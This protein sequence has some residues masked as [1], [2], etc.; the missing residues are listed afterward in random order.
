MKIKINEQESYFVELPEDIS[1]EH[2]SAI[3]D[4]FSKLL[5]M[6]AK[7]FPSET[8]PENFKS[9]KQSVILNPKFMKMK[10][11]EVLE[12]I[13]IYYGNYKTS[14]KKKLLYEK[15]VM[16]YPSFSSYCFKLIKN[17]NFSEEEIKGTSSN[18]GEIEQ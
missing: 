7:D 12:F 17:F 15:G 10:R 9:N 1:L 14:E 16:N 4:R 18:K 5:R 6:F 13:K 8:E 11:Q 3:N 2:L